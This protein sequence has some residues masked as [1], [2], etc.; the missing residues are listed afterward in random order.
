[1]TQLLNCPFCGSKDTELGHTETNWPAILCNECGALGPCTDLHSDK[2]IEM[3]NTRLSASPAGNGGRER[4]DVIDI[5]HRY[6]RGEIRSADETADA[7]LALTRAVAPDGARGALELAKNIIFGAKHKADRE[8]DYAT[9]H[10]YQSYI[11]EL[12]AALARP[13]EPATEAGNKS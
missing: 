3:W 11:D 4:A 10:E 6:R 7:I 12:D 1:M 9:S 2:A 13:L 5:C 8:R